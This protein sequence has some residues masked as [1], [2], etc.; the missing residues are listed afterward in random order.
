MVE[1]HVTIRYDARVARRIVTT[2]HPIFK[3]FS[4]QRDG[5]PS[6]WVLIVEMGR[7]VF[8]ILYHSEKGYLL[9]LGNTGDAL[10]MVIEETKKYIYI[11]R[12]KE[13]FK[14]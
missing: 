1:S 13:D 11:C 10:Q 8:N 9:T 14:Y 7:F 5:F 2:F 4:E 12:E 6:K 3:N